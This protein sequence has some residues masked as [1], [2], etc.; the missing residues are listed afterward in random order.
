MS[1]EAY[2]QKRRFPH[3]PEPPGDGGS[4]RGGEPGPLPRFVV[5]EHHAR[6]IHWD[7]RLEMEGVLR[8]W[9][10]PKGPPLNPQDKR[11]AVLVE[12]HPVAYGDFEGVIPPGHYGAGTVSI[13]DRG[14]YQCREGDPAEAFRRGKMTLVFHGNRLQGE[15]HLIR[16]RRHGGRDWLLVKRAER[17]EERDARRIGL[18]D[19]G[20]PPAR[21]PRDREGGDP[22]PSPF[23][24]M[25]AQPAPRPF[26]RPGWI[27]EVKWDGVRALAFVRRD[28]E[29]TAARLYSRTL[30]LLNAQFP[31]IVESLARLDVDSVVLDGEI[32]APDERGQPSFA[33]LQ[34][35]L[36]RP[37]EVGP[38][39]PAPAVVYTVFDCLYLNGRDLRARPLEERRARLA[40]L[41]LPEGI[42]LSE[43][44]E[45][46]GLALFEAV[47]AHGLEGI[48]AKD[49][50]SP[51]RPGN[52][53]AS[54]QKVKVRQTTDAVVGGFTQGRGHRQRSFGA[55]VLGQYDPRTGELVHIGQTGGGFTDADLRLLRARLLP[56]ATPTCPFASRPRIPGRVTWVRPE[57][58]VEVLYGEKTPGG[59]LRF[60]V[61]L[62][63]RED[64]K[65]REATVEVP[66][67]P[68]AP[69]SPPRNPQEP[70]GGRRPGRATLPPGLELT[71]LTKVF[72]PERGYTKAD[73]VEYYRKVA[74]YIIPHLKDRPLVLRRFPDGIG[75]KD[76]FQKD[77]PDAPASVRTERIWSDQGDRDITVPVG[78]DEAVL[79]WLA[80]LGCI[81]VHAWF[82]RVTPL[83]G[84]GT[85]SWAGSEEAISRSPLNYPDFVVF[86]LDPAPAAQGF[87]AARRA[88]LW[89]GELLEELGLRSF[90]KVSGQTGLHVFVPI[91][92]RYT[93]SQTHAFAKTVAA[94]LVQQHPDALT[95][96]WAVRDR[97]GK[98]F[99]DYNQNVRGKTLASVYSLR[100]VPE[101]TVSVPVT[102]EE[103]RAGVDPLRWTITTVFDRLARVGDLWRDILTTR[104]RLEIRRRASSR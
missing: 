63:I 37:P 3:T 62:R 31:D 11:L 10:V 42:V 52:R 51:Y 25:L 27:F 21:R 2:R 17:E 30:R 101:A 65:P 82:S 95:D 72:F 76:F 29:T 41:T 13:W 89:L 84:R 70:R 68:A 99:I 55:L 45:E 54:W 35:R 92:R 48:V 20:A 75:G 4:T 58:V 36:H 81:E 8:S 9:A 88:A 93:F 38:L 32:I 86:D 73:V 79:T 22:F 74:P 12:D 59:L 47:R 49:L 69:V 57:V 85:T 34:H 77:V 90:V 33:L 78:A 46:D 67:G 39:S 102:W 14:T 96:A 97:E 94:W 5:H 53:S 87:E 98:V 15:F 44:V 6:R 100:P 61:F 64:K 43:A 18:A 71:N 56:L 1:L 60:P 80:Q 66:G 104:Q 103:L 83:R 40:A 23:R 24:P 19:G 50:S 7:L 28:E 26:T 16:T 91:V